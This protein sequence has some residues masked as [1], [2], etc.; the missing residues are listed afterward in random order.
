M[1]ARFLIS[2]IGTDVGKTVASAVLARAW[3]AEYWKPVQTGAGPQSDRPTVERLTGGRVHTYPEVFAL[4]R[5]VSPDA[6]AA[7]E[8]VRI[9]LA[10]IA[11]ACPKHS[12]PLLIEGAGGL[13]VPLNES[14]RI[15]DMAAACGAAVIIVSRHYL[16]S[17]NHTLLSVE[18]VRSRGIRLAG[19]IFVGDEHPE[20]EGSI[21][22]FASAPVLGRIPWMNDL[23][24]TAIYEAARGIV[25]LAQ[26]L[27]VDL[28]EEDGVASDVVR[29]GGS[30]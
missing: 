22:R 6:A 3:D 13:L 4:P 12:R 11:V 20:T 30:W 23:S 2:G 21:R 5:P 7:S 10:E 26:V 16:G 28:A 15:V 17:I 27:A 19:I 1:T 29:S 8:G 18:A 24:V 14:E 9:S 25:S